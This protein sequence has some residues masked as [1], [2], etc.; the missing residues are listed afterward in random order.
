MAGKEASSHLK[1][2][3]SLTLFPVV[4]L[5]RSSYVRQRDGLLQWTEH[6]RA[7]VRIERQQRR[8]L[9]HLQLEDHRV[10]AWK[11]THVQV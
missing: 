9:Q 5:L 3:L 10:S 4:L 11:S 7:D 1:E 2:P 8:S 6:Q